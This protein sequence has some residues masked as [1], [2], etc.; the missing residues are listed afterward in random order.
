MNFLNKNII[1]TGASS[2]IGYELVKL[3]AEEGANL[4][5]LAR[6]KNVIDSLA[7]QLKNNTSGIIT[8]Q[9]DVSDKNNVHSAFSEIKNTF[10]KIDIVILNAGLDFRSA[11]SDT[12]NSKA[13]EIYGVNT[14]GLIYCINEVLNDFIKRKEGCIVGVSSL[15]DVRGFPKSGL[16]CSSK[17][18]A[19]TFLESLRV[20][21]K[22]YNIKVITVKP[23]FVKTP[24]TDKNEFYMPFLMDVEKATKIILNG[25]KKEKKIIRFPLPIVLGAKLVKILPDKLFDFLF[26]LPLP[27]KK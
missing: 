26:S 24:M 15:S 2:G 4:A 16:Y 8:L 1:L 9:C 7:A 13:D 22:K 21:L 12:D 6:R 18:A 10:G 19:S 3:L 5:L 27:S 25:I 14:L 11:V 20:E 17:A 23:G